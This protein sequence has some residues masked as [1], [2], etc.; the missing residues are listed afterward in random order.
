MRKYVALAFVV[1]GAA[2]IWSGSSVAA[3]QSASAAPTPTFNKDIAPIL[4]ANCTTCHRAGEVAPMSLMTYKDARPWARSI[5]AKV[6]DGTMPPWHADPQ[7]GK[8]KNERRLTDAQ[9]ATVA[10]WVAAGA[11]EGNAADLP[12]APAYTTSEWN[13]G[14][15][16]VVLSMQEDYPIPATGDVPYQYF[17][18]PAN[19]AEDRYIQSWEIKPGDRAAVHHIIVQ[20]LAP[21]DV[22]DQQMKQ[23]QQAV[24]QRFLAPKA[25]PGAPAQQ[26]QL[27]LLTFACCTNIPA[28][29]TGG[30]PLPKDQQKPLGPADRPRPAGTGPSVGGYVPG[31]SVRVFPEGTA[32]RLPAGYSLVF[33]MHYTTYGKATTDRSKMGLKF[34]TTKPSIVLNTATII[35]GSLDIPA[36]AANHEVD[37]DVT[38]NRD[39]MLY[40]LVPHTHVRGKRWLYEATYPDGRKEVL[41]SVPNY[42]FNWQH[43]YVYDQPVKIPAGTKLHASAWYDN[44]PANKSNPDPTKNV[45]WGDQTWEEMMYTSMTF[46]LPPTPQ[47]AA[48]QKH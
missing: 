19:F 2:V 11:P 44:S 20:T 25:A 43:E 4:Y 16:D 15:P 42:D 9:K 47:T 22:A 38:I 7:Y 17:E 39:I 13:I 3:Q 28:G 23:M 18:V 6:A 21:K 14:K 5:A 8:F 26:R 10:K 12:A 29:Q 24:M 36:Q 34:A 45:K 48:G 41:L 46:F 30:P 33:Q 32:M 27:P 37:A 40:S 35:N 31:N 1:L